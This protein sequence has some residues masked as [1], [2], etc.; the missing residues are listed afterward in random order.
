MITEV[1]TDSVPDFFPVTTYIKGEI[2]NIKSIGI[3]PVRKIT[4]GTHTDSSFVKAED[5]EKV[6]AD[7][8]SPVIDSINLKKSFKETKFLDQTLN[9]FTFSYDPVTPAADSF[10]FSHWDV[11]IDAETNAVRRVYMVKKAGADRQLQLT[12][13]SGKWCKTVTLNTAEKGGS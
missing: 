12:W 6:F 10:A 2:Y 7:F 9:A 11:Y 8:L 4:I 3:S 5:Y 13:Q 1:S